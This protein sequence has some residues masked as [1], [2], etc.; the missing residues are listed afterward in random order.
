[1]KERREHKGQPCLRHEKAVRDDVNEK[2]QQLPW[3][4][5]PLDASR[6]PPALYASELPRRSDPHAMSRTEFPAIIVQRGQPI[7]ARE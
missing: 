3:L 1:M 4:F 5:M 7:K 6:K 2:K